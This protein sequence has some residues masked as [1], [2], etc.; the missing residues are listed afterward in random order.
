MRIRRFKGPSLER[1]YDTISKEMGTEAV[2]IEPSRQ[3]P[4]K[5]LMPSF[6]GGES[7]EVIAIADDEAGDRHAITKLLDSGGLKQLSERNA[8]Q[9]DSL[10][11]AVDSLRTEIHGM[12]RTASSDSRPIPPR[13]TITALPQPPGTLLPAFTS[14]WDPRFVQSILARRPDLHDIKDPA[15]MRKIITEFLPPTGAFQA[16]RKGGPHVIV[17][18]G[19]TGS[20]KTT[21]LAKLAARWSLGSRLNVGLITTDT[22]RVAAVD[23][24]REYAVLLGLELKIAFSAAEAAK[25]IR[26]FATKDIILVDTVGRS[27]YDESG[28]KALHGV[29]N[30]MGNITSLLLVPATLRPGEVPALIRNYRTTGSTYL[31]ITKL[32]ETR[33]YD[34]LT[35]AAAEASMPIAFMTDGQRVPQDIHE[36]RPAELAALLVPT[37]EIT[38]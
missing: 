2:I 25:A 6:M 32:D 35:F 37:M 3:S 27:Q 16:Q 19:P 20:G 31:V 30:G 28:L 22:Y 7:H 26:T 11:K 1:I 21:T 15:A 34:V 9:M 4:L 33:S 17:L 13:R 18:T 14:N 12:S 23:Q 38:N 29:L 5:G 8:E 10:E 36:L 24:I